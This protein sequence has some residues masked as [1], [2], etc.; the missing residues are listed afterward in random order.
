MQLT[1]L[2]RARF[3][4][5]ELIRDHPPRFTQDHKRRLYEAIPVPIGG[6]LTV[7]RWTGELPATIDSP[8]P[9][10]VELVEHHFDYPPDSADVT[11]WHVNFADEHLFVAYGSSLMAQDELQCMEHPVLGALRQALVADRD[12]HPG[13][14]PFTRHD[15]RPAPVLV[16]G[17]QRSMAIDTS[18]GIY[19][20][21]FA[22]APFEKVREATTYL[23]PPTTSNIL[24]MVAPPGGRGP[25]ARDEIQ[26]IL[27]TACIGFS[28]CRAESGAT[29][30]VVHTGNWGTGAYGGDRVLMALLQLLAA[31]LAGLDRLVFHN[32]G[33]ADHLRQAQSLLSDLPM[34]DGTPIGDLIDA[35]HAL[36]FVWGIA[37]G[38]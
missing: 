22:R 29:V 13:L 32:S 1:E 4:A 28:A 23:D 20:N 14:A 17:V 5:A 30:A 26:D 9:T 7:S 12:A 3:D 31:R 6:T 35:V 21:A 34:A 27:A 25:Y 36:G 33:G 2:G 37:N 8:T 19:G 16:R 15:G 38:T 10:A 18:R 24:A 11:R